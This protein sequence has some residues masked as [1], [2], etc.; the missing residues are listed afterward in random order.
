MNMQQIDQMIA[1]ARAAVAPRTA[2]AM[3][4]IAGSHSEDYARCLNYVVTI[5]A[6]ISNTHDA[7][8]GQGANQLAAAAAIHALELVAKPMLLNLAGVDEIDVE[9]VMRL[10]NADR[11]AYKLNKGA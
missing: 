8:C 10:M 6:G 11:I 3:E 2:E 7:I 1:T 9:T 5:L 4:A